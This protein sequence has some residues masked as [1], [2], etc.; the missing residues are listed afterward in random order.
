MSKKKLFQIFLPLYDSQGTGIPI[1]HYQDLKVEL[2]EQF[3]GLTTY[4]RAPATGLW[5][6]S[7]D[8]VAVDKIIVYEVIADKR[9]PSYWK[10]LKIAL[11]KKF[12]QDEILIRCMNLELI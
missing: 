9:D 12:D 5:K 8:D 3:G 6:D 11:Q 1:G 4:S 2:T 7:N 10:N